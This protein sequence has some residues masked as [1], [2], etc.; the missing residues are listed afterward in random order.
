MWSWAC[1]YRMC[2]LNSITVFRIMRNSER[3]RVSSA[4]VTWAS[5]EL[6]A[7]SEEGS[8]P[9]R[10]ARPLCRKLSGPG[11]GQHPPLLLFSS[12]APAPLSSRLPTFLPSFLKK[13]VKILFHSLG[14]GFSFPPAP[15]WAQGGCRRGGN[16]GAPRDRLGQQMTELTEALPWPPSKQ[17]IKIL[18]CLF[19]H[20]EPKHFLKKHPGQPFGQRPIFAPTEIFL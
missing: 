9:A 5:A 3:V 11:G 20:T 15:H 4:A 12:P 16:E 6:A 19:F 8:W 18:P 14:W 7:V 10:K 13:D 1:Q 17:E 2:S